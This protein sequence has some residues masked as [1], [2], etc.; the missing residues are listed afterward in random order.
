MNPFIE[1]IN[2][3][4]KLQMCTVI[5]L[6]FP[7]FSVCSSIVIKRCID[8][9]L[10][11]YPAKPRTDLLFHF[12]HMFFTGTKDDIFSIFLFHVLLKHNVQPFCLFQCA[13]QLLKQFLVLCD[14]ALIR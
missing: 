5:L 1:H 11:V 9:R 2:A 7:E 12:V 3:K 13:A 10:A 4:K 6:K 8:P 14:E